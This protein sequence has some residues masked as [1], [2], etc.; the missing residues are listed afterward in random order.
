[1]DHASHPNI[2]IGF[3]MVLYILIFTILL[4]VFWT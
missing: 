4:T 2:T 3:N 1:M